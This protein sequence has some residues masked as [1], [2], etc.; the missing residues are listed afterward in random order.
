MKVGVWGGETAAPVVVIHLTPRRV[1]TQSDSAIGVFLR[2][3]SPIGHSR[4]AVM[5]CCNGS[6]HHPVATGATAVTA[7]RLVRTRVR[8]HGLDVDTDL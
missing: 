1:A 4:V 6:V 3:R 5:S 2:G 7:A 8:A